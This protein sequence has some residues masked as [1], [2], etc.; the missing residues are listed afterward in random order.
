MKFLK[1]RVNS[2]NEKEKIIKLSIRVFKNNLKFYK[3][4]YKL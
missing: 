4:T 2:Q 1:M 3:K